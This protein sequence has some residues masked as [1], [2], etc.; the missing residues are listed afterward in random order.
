MQLCMPAAACKKWHLDPSTMT[1]NNDHQ[2][3]P[4]P[5]AGASNTHRRLHE[6][7]KRSIER[8]SIKQLESAQRVQRSKN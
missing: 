8:V 7:S 2:Q 6:K 4:W 5:N 1:V 3:R